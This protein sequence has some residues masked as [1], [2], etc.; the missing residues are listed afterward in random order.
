MK[1]FL[2]SVNKEEIEEW[3]HVADGV[4]S[5]PY[6]LREEGI[7]YFKF[8]D[9]MNQHTIESF[10]QIFNWEEIEIIRSK[11]REQ[12]IIYKISMHPKYYSLIERLKNNSLKV[13]ATTVYDIVQINQ[14]IELECDYTM[15]YHHKNENKNLFDE[16][17]NLKQKSNSNIKLVGAS[18]RGKDEII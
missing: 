8:L 11:Y 18:L 9:Y 2:D 6:L 13:A 15:V 14:A 7:E 17:Y 4:T 5:N 3:L 16:A 10:V 12:E 1:Y